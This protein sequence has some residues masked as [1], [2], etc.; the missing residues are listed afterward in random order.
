MNRLFMTRQ[1]FSTKTLRVASR[2]FGAVAGVKATSPSPPPVKPNKM[3]DMWNIDERSWQ[4]ATLSQM[5]GPSVWTGEELVHDKHWGIQLTE[6]ERNDLVRAMREALAEGNIEF[7]SNGI[8]E[9]V[10]PDNF[11]LKGS[12]LMSKFDA[13]SENLENGNGVLMLDNFPI[14][15]LSRVEIATAYLGLAS[16]LG[17]WVPQSSAGLRSASRGFGLPLGEV[18]AE[19][20]GMT[21]S[22]GKQAN[23]Y[24]RLHTDRCDVISLLGIRTAKAGGYTRVCSVPKVY[25]E[26]LKRFPEYA[27]SMFAPFPRIWE[28]SGGLAD[29]PIWALCEGKFTTQFSPSYIENSQLLASARKLT[30]DEVEA[31]DLVEE[32]GIETGHRFLQGPGQLYFLNNHQVYH[33]RSSWLFDEQHESKVDKDSVAEPDGGE[34][35]LLYRIW[36]SPYNSRKIPDTPLF[37]HLW[38]NVEVG[39]PRG[40][41]EPALKSGLTE[42]PEEL[43]RQV[44]SGEHEYYGLYKRKFS[45]EAKYAMQ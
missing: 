35:R 8:P 41:L 14:E 20:K 31:L 10:N 32:I 19:M 27:R 43:V 7:S 34:G 4:T 26:M 30:Q 40:G 3:N 45:E 5:S 28:G 42:K 16:Y 13:W 37:R 12:T 21:P 25:N 17:Q 1:G 44:E 22:G 39:V 29:L 24:F 38:G 23:N 6:Q 11:K 9:N 36:L 2:R 18:R 33:G 15:G